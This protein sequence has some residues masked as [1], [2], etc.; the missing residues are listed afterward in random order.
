MNS[1]A[2]IAFENGR[3]FI[4]RRKAGGDL[5]GKWEFPGGKVEEGEGDADALK[6]EFLEEFAVA[7]EAGPLLA[8]AEFVHCGRGFNLN[9]YRVFFCSCSFRLAEHTEWR[10]ATLDEIAELDFADSDRRLL[11]GLKGYF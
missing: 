7:V 8:S 10:W 2:G 9:A 11:A 3:A 6:R 4:A 5:G 1:V